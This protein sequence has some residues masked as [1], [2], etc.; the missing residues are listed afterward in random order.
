MIE[1]KDIAYEDTMRSQILQD[2]REETIV[3]ATEIED[4]QENLNKDLVNKIE[5]HKK[6]KDIHENLVERVKSVTISLK[7]KM[8]DIKKIENKSLEVKDNDK[9]LPVSLKEYMEKEMKTGNLKEFKDLQL[10]V[11][12]TY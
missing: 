11:C 1:N 5:E 2:L 9:N 7:E 6:A 4:K 12:Y 8:M 3:N 10:R